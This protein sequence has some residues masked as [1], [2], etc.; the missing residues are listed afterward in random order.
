MTREQTIEAILFYKGEPVRIGELAKITGNTENEIKEAL[1]LLAEHLNNRGIILI[2]TNDEVALGT[3][4]EAGEIIRKIIKEEREGPI[5]KAALETLSVV[6]YHGPLS[7]PEIDY[8]RGVNS[9]FSLRN[10]SVRGLVERAPH[11]KDART[12]IYS[13]SIEL[14]AH[15]GVGSADKMPE[16]ASY[17]EK[18]TAALAGMKE[19]E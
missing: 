5:S 9:Q 7:K 8:I 12:H 17:R 3:H 15:L 19:N 6:L 4:P 18:I 2:H 11:P 13:G 16:Y 14:L 10:L 1:A